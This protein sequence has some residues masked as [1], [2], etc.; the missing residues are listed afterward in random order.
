VL[1]LCRD[2][3]Q[4]GWQIDV[5]APHAPNAA[6]REV[7]DG[8][9]VERFRYAWPAS[10]QTVC[11]QGGALINLRKRPWE[12]LKLPALVVCE[13]ATVQRRLLMGE[14]AL[15]HSHWVLPQGF[16]G[17]LACTVSRLPHVVTL[18]GG[19]LFALRSPFLEQL[20]RSALV[21][22]A[23][24]T[25]NSSFTESRT[26]ELAPSLERIERI[27]MG[28]DNASLRVAELDLAR[29]L[30]NE[31]RR[32]NGPLLV[33]LGR[34]VEEK[35]PGDALRALGLLRR[36]HPDARLLLIGEGQ[37]RPGLEQLAQDLGVGDAAVFLGWVDPGAVRAHLAS[38]DVFV[39]PSRT[40]PD[41]WVEAQGLSFLEAMAAG[42]PVVATRSGGIVD[43]V[44]D[45]KTGLLVDEAA[46]D[47]IDRAVRRIV[48]DDSLRQRLSMGGLALLERGFS[49]AASARRFS[50]VYES[51]V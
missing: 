49:R 41:G 12:K 46:P 51:L 33:F 48:E 29:R 24:V 6:R 38:A 19:D 4:L 35:G 30:R 1:H 42:I 45:E 44:H 5:V 7:L 47:Q 14:Y 13:W 2:L 50:E 9:D 39:G 8:I 18:H 28:V 34:L 32:G 36:T 15:V 27:P 37:D 40:A 11:Y 23:A 17:M 43:A 3:A 25:V 31:H 21:R 16:V 20:K 10:A 22:A 26:R